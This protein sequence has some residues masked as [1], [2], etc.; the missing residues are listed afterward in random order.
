ML[1][2]AGVIE[3]ALKAYLSVTK[4]SERLAH[5]TPSFLTV[6]LKS[7][8]NENKRDDFKGQKIRQTPIQYSKTNIWSALV[9]GRTRNAK[10]TKT[11][12][13]QTKQNE[14][15]KRS[16]IKF[17]DVQ[18]IS[19]G[20]ESACRPRQSVPLSERK[21]ERKNKL[22][23]NISEANNK[24]LLSI[25]RWMCAIFSVF[26]FSFGIGPCCSSHFAWSHTGTCRKW[27][28]LPSRNHKHIEL[29]L[30]IIW[31]MVQFIFI[32]RCDAMIW[33]KTSTHSN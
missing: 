1:N 2:K 10:Q 32:W 12:W 25:F 15:I 33:L 22:H 19:S 16:H 7:N 11:I 26:T 20:I 6:W 24:I 14:M 9:D 17:G 13:Q 21:K 31:K 3:M 30:S 27:R 28:V 18:I 23:L 29:G 5:G 8:D 4:A